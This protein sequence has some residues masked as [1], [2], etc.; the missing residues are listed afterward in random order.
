[1][2]RTRT[3]KSLAL[4]AR[5]LETFR[6]LC[7]YRFLRSTYL[8]AFVGGDS[9]KRFKERLGDLFHE[10]YLDRPSEQWRFADA[11]F[12]PV[13]HELGNGGRAAIA[14]VGL[15][16]EPF[17]WLQN[18]PHRQFEHSL[19]ICEVLSSI[20][21]AIRERQDLRFIAWPDILAKAP[22]NARQSVKPYLL[23]AGEGFSVAPD[24]LFGIEYQ[25]DGRK[26]Y[27]FFALE[28][29]RGTMPLARVG[30]TGTSV[31]AKLE[32]YH[33]SLS[34]D[35]HRSQLGIPNLLMLMVTTDQGRCEE[36]VRRLAERFGEMPQFLFGATSSSKVL[37]QPYTDLLALPWE[38]AG[39]PPLRIDQ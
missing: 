16:P 11:R 38:R 21:L 36:I 31:I 32:A 22:E 35:A 3:G 23:T 30:K 15:E 37:A 27:R 25:R 14:A 4:T 1:M 17:T 18:G 8:H 39:A 19:M 7:R 13:V 29:D 24:A 9:E 2:H 33:V 28:A 26:R 20:E 6:V 34:R 10:G 5:D 12:T